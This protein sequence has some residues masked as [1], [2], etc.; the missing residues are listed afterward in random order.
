MNDDVEFRLQMNACI[1]SLTLTG[2]KSLNLAN[3][4]TFE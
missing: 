3:S 2:C 1:S 4:V